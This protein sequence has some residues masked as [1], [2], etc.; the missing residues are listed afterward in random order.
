MIDMK[1]SDSSLPA[2]CL[3]LNA[4]Q[5]EKTHTANK[6]PSSIL[7]SLGEANHISPASRQLSEALQRAEQRENTLS[8]EGLRQRFTAAMN[9]LWPADYI[10]SSGK[11]NA[12]RPDTEDP[13]LL[14][15]ARKATDFENGTGP[16][17]FKGL[18]P[19]LLTA[20]AYDD[21]GTFT[22]NEIRL[23]G[24]R[25]AKPST[26]DMI[27]QW[28]AQQPRLTTLFSMLAGASP[29]LNERLPGGRGA[30][31]TALRQD[32]ATAGHQFV[33]AAAPATGSTPSSSATLFKDLSGPAPVHI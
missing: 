30:R 3:A 8:R 4:A 24:K 13:H 9:E 12:Q 31:F 19:E 2:K 5:Q 28:R 7:T 27:R 1:I 18:R 25:P 15:R 16:N 14:A 11:D 32:T 33:K 17:P 21:S 20:I 22:L 10:K 6:M 23:A 29:D 26:F